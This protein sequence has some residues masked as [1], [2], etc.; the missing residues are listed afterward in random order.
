M[1]LKYVPIV[2][3]EPYFSDGKAGAEQVAAEVDK[4]CRDIGFLIIKNHRVSNDLIES[5]FYHSRVFFDRSFVEEK[6]KMTADNR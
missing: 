5:M 1:T 2:D 3:L 4:A 6:V